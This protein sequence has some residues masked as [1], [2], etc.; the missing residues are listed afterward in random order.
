[1]VSVT[2]RDRVDVLSDILLAIIDII[3]GIRLPDQTGK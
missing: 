1:V 2:D 3:V